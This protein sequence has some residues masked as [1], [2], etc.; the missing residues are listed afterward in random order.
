MGTVIKRNE[1]IAKLG[2]FPVVVVSGAGMSPTIS[3]KKDP[4]VDALAKT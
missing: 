4:N 1:E 3:F 2:A